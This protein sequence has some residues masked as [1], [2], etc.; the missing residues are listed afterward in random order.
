M[1]IVPIPPDEP[2]SYTIP[3][4]FPSGGASITPQDSISLYSFLKLVSTTKDTHKQTTFDS[5]SVDALV[6]REYFLNVYQDINFLMQKYIKVK[7]YADSISLLYSGY[8]TR[9]DNINAQIDIYNNAKNVLNDKIS[10]MNNAINTINSIASPTPAQI[11]QYNN[12]VTTYNNYLT[13]TGNPAM[14]AYATSATNIYNIPTNIDNTVTIPAI[15][16]LIF[17]LDLHIPNVPLLTPGSISTGAGARPLASNYTGATI[18]LISPSSYP[19]INDLAHVPAP[20][21]KGDIIADYFLPFA[22]S[23]LAALAAG[24]KRLSNVDDYRAF[25]NFIL[26]QGFQLN[27][28]TVNAFIMNASKPQLPAGTVAANGTLGSLIVG[29]ESQNLE[30]ILST[31]LFNALAGKASI[32]IPP[33]IYDQIN[34]FAIALL[35]RIGGS[36]GIALVKTLGE[37]IKSLKEDN[38]AIDVA[39]A[40]AILQN[41]L[42]VVADSKATTD[43]LFTILKQVP[44]I[45]EQEARALTDKLVAAQNTSLLLL[46][47]LSTG[48]TLKSPNLV[49]DLVNTALSRSQ[50]LESS[51]S[52]SAPP[53]VLEDYDYLATDNPFSPQSVKDLLND[54]RSLSS[55]Q[56]QLRDRLSENSKY[57]TP[58]AASIANQALTSAVASLAPNAT[59]TQ[60]QQALNNQ[61]IN[62]GVTTSDAAIVSA[63]TADFV[64]LQTPPPVQAALTPVQLADAIRTQIA[65]V[66]KGDTT[67]SLSSPISEDFVKKLTDINDPTSFVSLL[68][69]Q[70][71]SYQ[72][73]NDK[74][75]AKEIVQLRR[76]FE[77]PNIDAFI[78]L[79]KLKDPANTLVLSFMTGVMYDRAIPTNWQKPLSIQV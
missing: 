7:S 20:K 74:E 50:T 32:S 41:I 60:F 22:E 21:S 19:D 52:S 71:K 12:A 65:E 34:V 18:P 67:R 24:S 44:G 33:N 13:I 36:A 8:N 59:P 76:E 9:V 51:S 61:L 66:L 1:P 75:I 68:S 57:L 26:K 47:G 73:L 5:Q 72:N 63:S 4:G 42:K 23:Y 2:V 64:K 43:A 17:D 29:V 58:S 69:S 79:E 10:D 6:N 46:G 62:L 16:Q 49:Q 28:A 70:L 3:I 39:L 77:R 38:P 25:V 55:V 11:T 45:T 27:P 54:G 40:A 14:L 48:L 53:S 78:I 35:A 30:R 31:A 37:T 15:N 56:T